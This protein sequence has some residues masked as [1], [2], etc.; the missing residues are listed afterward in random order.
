MPMIKNTLPVTEDAYEITITFGRS[1]ANDQ[2]IADAKF[3][4]FPNSDDRLLAQFVYELQRIAYIDGNIDGAYIIESVDGMIPRDGRVVRVAVDRA[5]E[6][7][8]AEIER[9]NTVVPPPAT[10]PIVEHKADAGW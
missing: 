6:D 1:R 8:N 9:L 2:E 4:C 5:W 7:A 3:G 10:S